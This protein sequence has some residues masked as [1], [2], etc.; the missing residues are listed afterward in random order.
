[1]ASSDRNIEASIAVSAQ[2]V[3]CLT[4]K[5]AATGGYN[6]MVGK[7]VVVAGG[8][9]G[10]WWPGRCSVVCVVDDFGDLV[11]VPA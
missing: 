2:R 6:Y 8:L 7:L 5:E 10:K 11:A 9:W 3:H 4:E 1:M